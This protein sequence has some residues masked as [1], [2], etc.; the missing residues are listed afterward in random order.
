MGEV[1]LGWLTFAPLALPAA[2]PGSSPM[3]SQESPDAHSFSA[4]RSQSKAVPSSGNNHFPL[5]KQSLPC[6]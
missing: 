5:W 1:G 6:C 3:G 4:Q 2:L